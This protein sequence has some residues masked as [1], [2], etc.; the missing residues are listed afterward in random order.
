[1]NA[2]DRKRLVAEVR[3]RYSLLKDSMDERV[4]RH[5]GATEAIAIGHQSSYG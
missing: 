2:A 1:V 3:Q 4:A 5:W